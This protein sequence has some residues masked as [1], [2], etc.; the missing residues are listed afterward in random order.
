[1]GLAAEEAHCSIRLSLGIGNTEEEIE[2]AVSL[3]GEII[4]TS[5]RTVRFVPCR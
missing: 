3:L 2:H 5:S 1:M 4:R